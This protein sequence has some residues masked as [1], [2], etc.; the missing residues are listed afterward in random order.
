MTPTLGRWTA[1]IVAS[2][3]ACFVLVLLTAWLSD[4][5]FITLRTVEN[6]LAGRGLTWN[7]GERVQVYTH[8]LWMLVLAAAGAVTGELY[9]SVYAASLLC[10]AAF[11]AGLVVLHGKE[12]R[13]LVLVLLALATSKS[14]V[15]FGTGG[16]EN[17]LMH[18]L[19][20]LAYWVLWDRP[21]GPRQVL[22]TAFL[23]AL[24]MTTRLDGLL[25]FAPA[26]A[27]AAWRAR[28]TARV[29]RILAATALGLA[30]LVAWE[31]FSLVYN[32]FFLPNVY[33]AKLDT[34]VP[35]AD[36]VDQGIRYLFGSC[37]S[38]PFVYLM[39]PFALVLTLLPRHR[40]L[41]PATVACLLW[42]AYVVKIGGD[43]MVGR[44]LTPAIVLA[45]LILARCPVP[46]RRAFVVLLVPI[47]AG[48]VLAP[49]SP[50]KYTRG[51][52]TEVV[53]ARLGAIYFPRGL[54]D[55][56]A[57]GFPMNGL[58]RR[59]KVHGQV[60]HKWAQRGMRMRAELAADPAAKRVMVVG[61][62]GQLP[63]FAGPQL[64]ALDPLALADPL[65]ARIPWI[66]ATRSRIGHQRRIVPDGYVETL[67]SGTN[68]IADP[69]LAACYDSLRLV[70]ASERIWSRERFREIWAWNT[71]RYDALIAAYVE[72]NRG[73]TDGGGVPD[74]AE[75]P[76]D[77]Q[78]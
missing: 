46:S 28:A 71:G 76:G 77:E 65:L 67:E 55:E 51:Y 19:L 72:R 26:W 21:A 48:A 44:H 50:W 73:K 33:Y 39:V 10:T 1:W 30:P 66:D 43:F 35:L 15:D 78:R 56:R 59:T 53:I 17:P 25:L 34:G 37:I 27:A 42:L 18:L 70:V 69:D 29:P 40:H 20:C 60:D 11:L 57:G 52:D 58:F 3:A 47:V 45:A 24:G 54:G 31:L 2:A 23:L 22:W 75:D 41:L 38:D 64:H 68:R 9:H 4:D 32:G 5:A 13:A 8:P 12:P 14:F 36:Y 6:F 16:L 7:P 49:L 61:A 62:I 74:A 63:F